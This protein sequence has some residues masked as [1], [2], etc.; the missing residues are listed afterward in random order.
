MNL[1]QFVSHRNTF[2]AEELARGVFAVL[3]AAGYDTG[4]TLIEAVSCAEETL[5][6]G[7]ISLL[8]DEEAPR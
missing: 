3:Q 1:E 2:P 6:G 4:E 8:P 7:A 5:L